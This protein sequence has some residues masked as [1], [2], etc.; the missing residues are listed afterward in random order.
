MGS[1]FRRFLTTELLTRV[2]RCELATH[3]QSR[4]GRLI[5]LIERGETRPGVVQ[6][7]LFSRGQ[8]GHARY[9]HVS[10][11]YRAPSGEPGPAD[12]GIVYAKNTNL[13][14]GLR[15]ALYLLR[16]NGSTR[17][18]FALITDGDAN[19]EAEHLPATVQE[20]GRS[21]ARIHTIG[22]GNN[23][24]TG[25]DPATLSTIARSTGGRFQ[26]AHPLEALCKALDKAA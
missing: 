21:G 25:Y 5:G 18:T 23:G 3:L 24:D 7:L 8:G 11:L 6:A 10:I 1:L 26:S 17:G 12:D 13:T 2:G 20:A 15:P 14:S 4:I 9:V 22:I 16:E 19:V